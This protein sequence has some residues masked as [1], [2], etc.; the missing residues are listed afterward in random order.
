MT[1]LVNI[2]VA[3]TAMEALRVASKEKTIAIYNKVGEDETDD[4][5]TTIL[6]K[7]A[8]PKQVSS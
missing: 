5:E 8:L 2:V 7:T 3:S 1:S 6:M 4:N